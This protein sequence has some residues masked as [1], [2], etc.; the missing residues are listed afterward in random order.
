MWHVPMRSVTNVVAYHSKSERA[1]VGV[2]ECLSTDTMALKRRQ[3]KH[4]AAISSQES[5]LI[6]IITSHRQ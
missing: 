6:L 1:S 2:E 5:K 4:K 3:L